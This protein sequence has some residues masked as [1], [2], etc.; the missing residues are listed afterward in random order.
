MTSLNAPA[1]CTTKVHSAQTVRIIPTLYPPLDLF[2]GLASPE[3]WDAL[4]ELES[5]TN[6][7]LRDAVGEISLVPQDERVCGAG[8]TT[9]MAAFTHPGVSRFS[10]GSYGVYYAALDLRT[11][12]AESVHS[13]SRFYADSREPMTNVEMRAHYGTVKGPL[14]D[15]R[16]GWPQVHHPGDLSDAQA[17]AQRLR[18]AGSYGVIYDSVRHPRGTCIGVFRPSILKNKCSQGHTWQ[19]PLF[20][21]H[22]D[23]CRVSKYFD[24][25]AAN[26]IA[27]D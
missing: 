21:Y 22:W 20:T 5:L 1:P 15:L 7:R 14:H 16:G 12:I 25:Q 6:D 8:S 2:E 4:A 23:G 24:H 10:D 9:I 17:L 19:G 11:A 27:L 18:R 13:R 26:W 3:D